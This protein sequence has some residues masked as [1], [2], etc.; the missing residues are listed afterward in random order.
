MSTKL[1]RPLILSVAIFF[2]FAWTQSP[3]LNSY[4]LQLTGALIL[5]YFGSKYLFRRLGSILMLET[6]MLISVVL[7][8]IFSSGGINS[9]IFFVLF[10]L[11]FVIALLFDPYQAAIASFLLVSLFLWQNFSDLSSVM[12]IDITSLILMTPLAMIFSNSYLKYLQSEGKISLLKEA[13]KDEQTDSLLWIATTAKP[14]LATILNSLTDI[15]IYLNSKGQ[16]VTISK[17]FIEKLKAIQKDLISLYSSTD[18]LEK[19]I[20]ETS[21][22]M[23]L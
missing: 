22:K 10:F 1:V 4:N 15:V 5:L 19:S 2:I 7:L 8:L 14:S 21:D 6:V 23:G 16:D 11:L 12:I 18:I 20:E 13:I 9:P 17:S 3:V